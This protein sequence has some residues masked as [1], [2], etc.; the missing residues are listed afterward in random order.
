LDN[1]KARSWLNNTLCDLVQYDE[2]GEVKMDTVIPLID[3]GTEGFGGQSRVFLPRLTSCFECSLV[4]MPEEKFH[5]A[6]CTIASVPRIPEHCISYAM[7]ILWPLL[8]EFTTVSDYKMFVKK[9]EKDEA[10]AKVKLDKDNLDHMS[11]IYHRACER[12]DKFKIKGVSFTMTQQV[13][14]NIIPAIASTNAL[15][16]A[17][18]VNE[19][20]KFKTFS[21]HRLDN[22]LMYL[23]AEQTGINSETFR[24]KKN[25]ECKACHKPY[26][27]KVKSDTTLAQL[28]TILGD[29]KGPALDDP[30]IT[31]L[32]DSSALYLGGLLQEEVHLTNL[33]KSLKD[34]E[35]KTDDQLL[36]Q[37]KNARWLK[38]IIKYT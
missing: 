27:A 35:I 20:L 24:Y 30:N 22:Y 16:S 18:C 15:V 36:A 12:A 1:V 31:R 26:I 13:V 3:G 29:E 14:K 19:A 37:D 7:K 2:K 4:S 6:E 38:I 32:S 28:R 21:S 25:E 17:E 33:T 23:G 34:L 5:F 11:W 9:D 10:P 8:E